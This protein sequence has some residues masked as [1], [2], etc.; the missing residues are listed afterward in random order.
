MQMHK[1]LIA[2]RTSLAVLAAYDLIVGAIATFSPRT[3]YDR[4]P[5]FASWVRELPPYN[6]HL[7]SDVGELYLGLGV[8][9]AWAACTRGPSI[10]RA[11]CAG[12]VVVGV[13]HL[14]FH[15]SHLDR[16]D[17]GAIVELGGLTAVILLPV[18]ALWLVQ[19]ALTIQ[20]MRGSRQRL[21]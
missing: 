16:L 10:V 9:V 4:F 11:A 19:S 5:F 1:R 17:T 15:A 12:S 3:F 20:A 2:L 8:I 18:L 14:W 13:L 7:T 21:S 6:H